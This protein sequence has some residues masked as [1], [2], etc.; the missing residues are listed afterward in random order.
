MHGLP[1][2]RGDDGDAVRDLQLRLSAV[3]F[4]VVPGELGVFGDSTALALEAF[5]V[6]RGLRPD[7]V[8]GAQTW[9]SLVE[10]GF[11]LGDRLL[12]EARPML[13]GDDV[14]DLQRRLG[15]LGFDAGRVDGI[16]GARTARSLVDFQRNAGLTVDGICGPAT[17][18]SLARLGRRDSTSDLDPVSVSE[19][20]ERELLR[21][22]PRTLL[23][24]TV[25]LGHQGGADALLAAVARAIGGAGAKAMA[26]SEP[27][28][29]DQAEAA[30]ALGADVFVGLTLEPGA[31]GAS[32]AYW[33]SPRHASASSGGRRLAEL[34][35][36]RLPVALGVADGGAVGMS[37]PVLRETRMT[38]VV[39]RLGPPATVVEHTAAVAGAVAVALDEWAR[40]PC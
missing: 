6:R 19:V 31:S 35:Q 36:A 29:L 40:E 25:A 26:L 22:G 10:A 27:D 20:R 13:R 18:A 37:L 32:T 39:C 21:H 30:N 15:A 38:A 34:L 33:R 16:F 28:E 23:G 24:R 1:L 9:A 7:A 17:L 8:C 3:G 4:D 5:Q 11:R 14:A 12:Y 2:S